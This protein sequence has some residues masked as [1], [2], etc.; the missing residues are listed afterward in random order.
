[1]IKQAKKLTFILFLSIMIFACSK[2]KKL[3]MEM[4]ATLDG[5][6]AVKATILID[7]VE[8]G[9]TDDEGHFFK[10]IERMPGTVRCLQLKRPQDTESRLGRNPL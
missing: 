4:N 1:M 8:E 5:K 10:V 3:E 2:G 9:A 6:P 7:G